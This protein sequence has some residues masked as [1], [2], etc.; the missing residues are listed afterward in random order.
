[1]KL[2]IFAHKPPPH[3]GQS[4][5]VQLLLEQLRG[6]AATDFE[7]FHVDSRFSKDFEDIGG[8]RFGKLG[9]LLKYCLKAI[10]FRLRYGVLAFYFVP[11]PP[12]R[13]TLY[14]DWLVMLLCRP[15]FPQIIYH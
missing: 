7:V 2:L 9:S 12:K 5:M 4:Y 14:R 11:A 15:F 10:G 13:A 1:M 8:F 6:D 3:H